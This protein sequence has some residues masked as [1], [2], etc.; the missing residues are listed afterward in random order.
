MGKKERQ[1]TIKWL[2]YSEPTE[3]PVQEQ[4]LIQAAELALDKAHAPYSN[5]QVGAALITEDGTVISGANYENAAYPMCLCAERSAIAAAVSTYPDARILKMAITVKSASHVVE[6]PAAPCGACRQSICEVEN[7]HGK[8]MRIIL[9]GET[10]D[11]YVLASGRD[12]LPLSFD[13][14]FL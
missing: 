10:G 11:I 2:A 4:E 7:H 12:L 6:N 1:L 5:F 14:Q 13:G 3:L 8:P 9:Q